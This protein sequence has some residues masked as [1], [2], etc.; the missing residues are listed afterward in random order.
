[1]NCR[2]H[3]N[4]KIL[5][6]VLDWPHQALKDGEETMLYMTI[7]LCSLNFQSFSEQTLVHRKTIS[8]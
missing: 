2:K 3:R 4:C 6:Y 5:N 1:M 7:R 8:K